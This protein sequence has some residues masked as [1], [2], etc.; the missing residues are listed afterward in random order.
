MQILDPAF[1]KFVKR[2]QMPFSLNRVGSSELDANLPK[3]LIVPQNTL[4]NIKS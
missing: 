3:N 2:V 1:T 4:N